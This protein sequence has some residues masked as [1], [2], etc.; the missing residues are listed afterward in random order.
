MAS[1]YAALIDVLEEE[2][3]AS[4]IVRPVMAA[5]RE[6]ALGFDE[7]WT[8]ALRAISPPRSCSDAVRE[9]IE[10]ERRLIHETKPW[11]RAAYAGESAPRRSD[12]TRAHRRAAHRLRDL[13]PETEA[14][15]RKLERAVPPPP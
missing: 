15:W 1:G 11:W 14:I 12:A 8:A 4:A 10:E 3:S 2:P 7:A 6:A 13:P 5:A 9:R